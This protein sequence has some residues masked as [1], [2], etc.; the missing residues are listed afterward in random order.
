M[1]LVATDSS[2]LQDTAQPSMY[3]FSHASFG[4]AFSLQSKFSGPVPGLDRTP[5]A[6][7]RYTLLVIAHAAA[8]VLSVSFLHAAR[9]TSSQLGGYWRHVNGRP[10]CGSQ[11]ATILIEGIPKGT[12][13]FGKP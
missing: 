5:A 8:K 1:V 7:E 10:Q 13:K 12:P 2:S 4:T 6:A 3:W 11:N 9:A